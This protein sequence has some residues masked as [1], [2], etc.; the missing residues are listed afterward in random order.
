VRSF[1]WGN[2]TLLVLVGLSLSFPGVRIKVA[3]VLDGTSKILYKSV[4]KDEF[5]FDYWFEKLNKK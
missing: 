2:L 3:D 1:I 4:D 5:N